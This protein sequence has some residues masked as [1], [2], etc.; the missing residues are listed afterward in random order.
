MS[1]DTIITFLCLLTQIYLDVGVPDLP[2]IDMFIRLCY[3]INLSLSRCVVNPMYKASKI[4]ESMRTKAFGTRGPS[5]ETSGL[6]DLG[7][8]PAEAS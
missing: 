8:T 6:T 2:D 5:I 1:T 4:G 3:T 7:N